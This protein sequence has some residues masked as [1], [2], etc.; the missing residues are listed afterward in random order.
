MGA[1]GDG[2]CNTLLVALYVCITFIYGSSWKCEMVSE[3]KRSVDKSSEDSE[4]VFPDE[5]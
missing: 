1:H 5:A 2:I 4:E 3:A